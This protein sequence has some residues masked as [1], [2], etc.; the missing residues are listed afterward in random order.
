MTATCYV[1]GKNAFIPVAHIVYTTCNQTTSRL[2]S[3]RNQICQQRFSQFCHCYPNLAIGGLHAQTPKLGGKPPWLGGPKAH[4]PHDMFIH[5]GFEAHG[6][7]TSPH[8]RV[9]LLRSP[10]QRWLR[11]DYLGRPLCKSVCVYKWLCVKALVCKAV[12]V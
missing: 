5:A 6:N 11:C 3:L 2:L 7:R 1:I 8:H 4:S 10:R 12:C 9:G